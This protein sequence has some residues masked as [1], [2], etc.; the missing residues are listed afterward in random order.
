MKKILSLFLCACV[1]LSCAAC[2]PR[3]KRIKSSF[4]AMDTFMTI[5]LYDAKESAAS[6]IQANI[7]GL[8]RE[9]SATNSDDSANNDIFRLNRDGSVEASPQVLDA[10]RQAL[11]LCADTDGALDIT[12][13]P[14]VEEWGFIS[15]N[16]QIPTR[17]RLAQLLPLVDY[18][19][20]SIDDTRITLEKPGMKLDFGAVAKGYAADVCEGILKDQGVKSALINLG[21]T[22][23][24]HGRN[25]GGSLWKIGVADP[26][27]SAG[28]MGYVSCEDR[29]IATSGSYERGF[30]GEDGKTYSHIIDPETGLPADNGITSVTVISDSGIRCDGLSTALFVMGRE[31]AE[32]YYRD[33]GGFDYILLTADGRAYVTAGIAESFT[34]A[35]GYDYEII[36]VS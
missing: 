34:Q 9:L 33:R 1:L 11:E 36:T 21:G 3:R 18:R 30:V 2:D 20:V 19:R 28:Y 35:D 16:Y 10:A 13:A 5:E 14:R 22:I 23:V 7:E 24:A 29:I 15:K 26:E 17:E 6:G 32:V 27:N 8:D 25:S 12:V 4:E 31:K